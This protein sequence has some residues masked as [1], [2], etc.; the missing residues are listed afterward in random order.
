MN[1]FFFLTQEKNFSKIKLNPHCHRPYTLRLA[2]KQAYHVHPAPRV[3]SL[4]H[5]N[6]TS[7]CCYLRTAYIYSTWYR[8]V[9]TARDR[10]D[11]VP[12]CARRPYPFYLVHVFLQQFRNFI[13]TSF[14]LKVTWSKLALKPSGRKKHSLRTLTVAALHRKLACQQAR[15]K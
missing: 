11:Q 1:S 14:D 3:T 10:L 12:D 9:A 6:I 13:I 8:L 7:G 2:T 4:L 5:T 15:M